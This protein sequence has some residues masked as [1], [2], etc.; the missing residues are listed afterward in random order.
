MV[1]QRLAQGQYGLPP[2]GAP[3]FA[4]SR[5]DHGH[6]NE[7]SSVRERYDFGD[8]KRRRVPRDS[9]RA[10]PGEAQARAS[11][12]AELVC[13]QRAQITG[14]SGRS[15][16]NGK[17]GT[18]LDYVAESGRWGMRIEGSGEGVRLKPA[19]IIG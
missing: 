9:P 1:T 14:L 19:N 6:G 18:V 8:E 4:D 11:N 5:R 7:R 2:V 15:D 13:G 10:A 17:F 12:G 3:G 16:L